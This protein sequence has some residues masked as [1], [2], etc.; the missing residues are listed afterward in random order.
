M[1]A[2]ERGDLDS[3]MTMLDPEIEYIDPIIPR[4]AY[5]KAEVRTA[6]GEPFA[7]SRM[8]TSPSVM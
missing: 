6:L 1:E 3:V 8:N 4:P 5:G 7:P 2:A